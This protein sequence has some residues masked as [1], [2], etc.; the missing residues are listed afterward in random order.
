MQTVTHDGSQ[1]APFVVGE[2]HGSWIDHE[3]TDYRDACRAYLHY[4]SM[5]RGARMYKLGVLV[6]QQGPG[7][8]YSAC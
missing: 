6:E 5:G 1:V 7:A 4:R 2:Y 8:E 3:Y